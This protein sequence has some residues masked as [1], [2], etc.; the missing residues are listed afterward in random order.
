MQFYSQNMG[1]IIKSVLMSLAH[2]PSAAPFRAKVITFR[3]NGY[4][5]E[6]V[7]THL[8]KHALLPKGYRD[9]HKMIS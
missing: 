8:A 1:P 4:F 2:P 7:I 6:K 5:R 9:I 3:Q